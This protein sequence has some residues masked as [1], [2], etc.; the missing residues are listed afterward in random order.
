MIFTELLFC[1]DVVFQKI[2]NDVNAKQRGCFRIEM[3][4]SVVHLS[5]LNI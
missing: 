5:F 3:R 2:W 1:D 4:Y